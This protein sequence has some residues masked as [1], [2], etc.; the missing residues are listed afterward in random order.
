[1]NNSGGKWQ[2]YRQLAKIKEKHAHLL[3]LYSLD[4]KDDEL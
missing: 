2:F 3:L 4:E 1:M